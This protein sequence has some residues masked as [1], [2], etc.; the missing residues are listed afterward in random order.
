[1]EAQPAEGGREGGITALCAARPG[2]RGSTIPAAA[3]SA[4]RG[5][6]LLRLICAILSALLLLQ[7]VFEGMKHLGVCALLLFCLVTTQVNSVLVG[8]VKGE[9]R[10]AKETTFNMRLVMQGT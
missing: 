5:P 4:D 7:S 3:A 10:K 1:M 8:R 2:E 6:G 9:S